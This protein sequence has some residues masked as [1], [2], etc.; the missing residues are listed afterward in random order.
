MPANTN[1]G[2]F[3]E[4]DERQA[5]IKPSAPDTDNADTGNRVTH[6]SSVDFKMFNLLNQQVMLKKQTLLLAFASM[7]TMHLHAQLTIKGNV[8]DTDSLPTEAGIPMTHPSPD[9]LKV[10][11]LNEVVVSG[12]RVQKNAPFAPLFL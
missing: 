12:V 3:P 9:T 6:H 5:E 4:R 2:A 1:R 7:L 8:L 10:H 11:E